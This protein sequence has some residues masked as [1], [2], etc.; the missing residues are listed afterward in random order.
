MLCTLG[1]ALISSKGWSTGEVGAAYARA[2]ELSKAI[3]DDARLFDVL[4]GIWQFHLARSNLSTAIDY[5]SQMLTLAERTGDAGHLLESHRAFAAASL[6]R[7]EF[8]RAKRHFEGGNA[9]KDRQEYDKRAA[10][11]G[12]HAGVVDNLKTRCDALS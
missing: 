7:G 6:W 8:T 5:G 10:G 11:Y 3:G 9:V 4:R 12:H 1:P 2:M